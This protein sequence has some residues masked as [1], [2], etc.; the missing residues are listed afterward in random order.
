MA[1]RKHFSGT[2]VAEGVRLEVGKYTVFAVR[3]ADKDIAVRM[4]REPRKFQRLSMRMPFL[5]GAVR[6]VRDIY[7]FLDGIAESAELRPQRVVR[8]TA[9]EQGI[10]RFLHIHPQGIVTLTSAL[11]M[12]LLAF[13]FLFAAPQG[14]E[15][16]LEM[17]FSLTRAWVNGIVCGIRI[18][19]FLL[20]IAL[21]GQLRVLRRLR[22]YRCAINM[23]TNCYEHRGD[24]TPENAARYS[25]Y[26]RRSEPAFVI[27]V[28]AISMVLFSLVRTEA[29]W[30]AVLV[31]LLILLGVAAIINE[32]FSALE[33]AEPGWVTRILRTPIDLIQHMT[34]LEPHPQMLEVAVCAFQA[35]L[36]ELEQLPPRK[37]SKP[38]EEDAPGLS[39]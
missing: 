32:P 9:V 15:Q 18:C 38:K 28:T 26:A 33:E 5:R 24:L 12:L 17:H 7:R 23:V 11:L 30:V 37:R 4:R 19:S 27:C 36:G 39:A 3:K 20:F 21:A 35:A 6:Y 25:C 1:K 16:M 14:A 10:A 34:T 8:G 31:R 22:M 2:P 13:L 29:L